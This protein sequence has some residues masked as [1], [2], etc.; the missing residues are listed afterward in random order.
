[1]ISAHAADARAHAVHIIVLAGPALGVLV[2]VLLDVVRTRLRRRRSAAEVRT[3]E[4]T[5]TLELGT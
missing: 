2:W 4:V 3:S 1:V 5:G